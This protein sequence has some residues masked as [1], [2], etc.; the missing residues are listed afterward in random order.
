[1]IRKYHNHKLQTTRGTARKSRSTITRHQE[2]KLSKA[3][4]SLFP[5]KIKSLSG[6]V[7]LGVLCALYMPRWGGGRTTLTLQLK[8]II[9]LPDQI[10]RHMFPNYNKLF[11]PTCKLI[12]FKYQWL[13]TRKIKLFVTSY[14]RNNNV[15]ENTL[16]V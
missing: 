3:I 4:R 8:I 2:D 1:M 13:L 5:I 6:C 14:R 15:S 9:I 7:K 16:Q 10:I 11:D 12:F